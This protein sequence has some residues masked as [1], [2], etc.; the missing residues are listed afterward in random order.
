MLR[1]L[2]QIIICKTAR[3]NNPNI[4]DPTAFGR[5]I[6]GSNFFTVMMHKRAKPTETIGNNTAN[7]FRA[8]ALRGVHVQLLVLS[9][10]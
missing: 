6:Q 2:Y 5:K 3:I 8:S 4:P 9:V 7:V 1:A 10:Y